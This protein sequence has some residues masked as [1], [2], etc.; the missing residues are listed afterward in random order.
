MDYKANRGVL[1]KTIVMLA[2]PTMMEE[3]LH[4][5]V[6]YIDSA[7]VG[8]LGAQATAAVGCT[9][10]VNWLIGSSVMASGIGFLSYISHELGAGRNEQ[11]KRAV[12]QVT[13]FILLIG[14]AITLITLSVAK[15]IPVWM[16]AAPEIQ[17]A[18]SSYFFIVYTPML[19]RT[20][21]MLYG[22]CLRAA[23]DTK[24]P[25][26]I[27]FIENIINIVL[28]FVLIYPTRN[29]YL[30]GCNVTIPGAGM[31]VTG[32]AI[33][34]AISFLFAGIGMT[35][36]IF[37]HPRI[38]PVGIPFKPDRRILRP[39]MRISFPC[40]LQRIG[41]SFGYVVFASMINSIGTVATA[42]HSIANTA[43]SA[44]YIPAYGMQTAASTLSG[45]CWG[46]GNNEK[47]KE[48]THIMM[49][50]EFLLMLITG[51]TLFIFA[52]HLMSIFTVDPAVI[53][54][55]TR[56]LRMVS[57]T[58]PV[59]GIAIIL[60]G[61]FQGVGDTG[62]IF[63]FDISCMWGIRVLGTF[64]CVYLFHMGLISAWACMIAHNVFLWMLLTLRYFKGKWNPLL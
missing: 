17:A 7:M 64:I 27:T 26:R 48:T 1:F 31:G 16:N 32:A 63:I 3:I 4:T 40:I 8:S 59:Y 20:A 9:Q 52:C 53:A 13:M 2:W 41:T 14:F 22:T 30:F 51:S 54:L 5:A 39:V 57:V 25:L 12:S 38:S 44:F 37:K 43:E 28:N 15:F 60:I 10:T 24:T 45:N 33:A 6:S 55:G 11:A 56:V 61:I 46:E 42:A 34:S 29:V 35:I 18:A 19:A 47:L 23:G 21:S 36:S 49:V 58:E 62:W 50:I